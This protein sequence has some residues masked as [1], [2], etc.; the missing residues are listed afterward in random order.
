MLKLE[1]VIINSQEYLPGYVSAPVLASDI[2][3]VT[4]DLEIQVNTPGGEVDGLTCIVAAVN[5]WRRRCPS[6][7]LR[8]EVTGIAASCGAIF[9]LEI[10]RPCIVTAPAEAMLMFHGA[11][12]DYVSGGAEIFRDAADYLDKINQRITDDLQRFGIDADQAARMTS[13]G[14]ETWMT[15]REAAELGIITE[16]TTLEPAPFP[17]RPE[18]LA[19]FPAV[20]CIFPPK[21]LQTKGLDTMDNPTYE[22][23]EELL[24][25]AVP[26]DATLEEKVREIIT[27]LTNAETELTAKSE[28]VTQLT[29][30][31]TA[32]EEDLTAKGEEIASL[33]EEVKAKGEECQRVMAKLSRPAAN[34]AAKSR[35][36]AQAL[37]EYRQAHPGKSYDSAFCAVAK[38]HPELYKAT[39]HFK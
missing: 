23:I 18:N 13:G 5:R 12:L 34:P 22:I 9:L 33:T 17:A 16:V 14:S 38:A 8:I 4:G 25:S 37:D 24:E 29:E 15:A 1:G 28:E 3:D 35:T 31:I 30:K 19:D 6:A 26:G 36:F 2:D 27:R 10:P 32:L 7:E 21:H 39:R 11:S 20:A